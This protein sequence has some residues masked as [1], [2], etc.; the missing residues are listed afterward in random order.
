MELDEIDWAIFKLSPNFNILSKYIALGASDNDVKAFARKY[1]KAGSLLH[2]HFMTIADE[3]AFAKNFEVFIDKY[4]LHS[5]AVNLCYLIL[6]E[7][8][9]NY[10]NVI[11]A[12]TPAKHGVNTSTQI[13]DLT[14]YL[15]R[16]HEHD[17]EVTFKAKGLKPQ[18]SKDKRE[19]IKAL[20]VTDQPL[21][22]WLVSNYIDMIR[23]KKIPLT[24]GHHL[25]G[26]EIKKNP[27]TGY[28]R[29]YMHPDAYFEYANNDTIHNDAIADMSVP[30]LNYL[31]GET[32]IKNHDAKHWS[33]EQLSVVLDILIM[34]KYYKSSN[35]RYK[36]SKFKPNTIDK[37][38]LDTTLNNKVKQGRIL[39]N[40]PITNSK[41]TKS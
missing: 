1:K 27:K 6:H 37:S 31:Q 36:I 5:H 8:K 13:L 25:F 23:Q 34:L 22:K 32:L 38:Y 35:S 33:F 40:S 24:M 26:S 10:F 18:S 12:R 28:E 14:N 41:F 9:L 15:L 2:L 7:H 16:F 3:D 39:V 4:N 30:L 21:V 20:K 17:I 29:L 19:K 11:E